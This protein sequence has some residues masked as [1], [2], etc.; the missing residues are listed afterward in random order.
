MA[1]ET[2]DYKVILEQTYDTTHGFRSQH[3]R[4]HGGADDGFGF[5]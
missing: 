3:S 2:G 5:P 4:R 1:Y